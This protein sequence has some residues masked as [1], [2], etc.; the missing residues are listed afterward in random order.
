MRLVARMSSEDTVE[1][2]Q[3][4]NIFSERLQELV[5]HTAEIEAIEAMAL[6]LEQNNVTS[7]SAVLSSE[8][9]TNNSNTL[10]VITSNIDQDSRHSTVTGMLMYV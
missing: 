6:D 3:H 2:V 7:D 8:M 1:A 9:M 5:Y 4:W 10:P